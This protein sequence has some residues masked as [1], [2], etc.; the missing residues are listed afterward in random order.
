VSDLDPDQ[1]WVWT[2]CGTDIEATLYGPYPNHGKADDALSCATCDH[3]HKHIEM[4][5]RQVA[6]SLPPDARFDLTLPE[7]LSANGDELVRP[8]PLG[9]GP[10]G[11]YHLICDLWSER[12]S[13]G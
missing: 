8:H 3:A 10:R 11:V 2:F 9:W 13:G 12:C 1:P 7:V 4:T 6:A 5:A